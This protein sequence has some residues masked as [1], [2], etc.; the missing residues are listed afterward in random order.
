MNKIILLLFILF[1]SM[2][3]AQEVLIPHEKDGKWGYISF[4]TKKVVVP[5]QFDQADKYTNHGTASVKLGEKWGVL[6]A[7]GKELVPVKY[8]FIYVSERNKKGV[9]RFRLNEKWGLFDADYNIIVPAKYEMIIRFHGRYT[10]D[11]KNARPSYEKIDLLY[12]KAKKDG[13][14]GLIDQSD[15]VILSFK[16]DGIAYIQKTNSLYLNYNYPDKS[17]LY[18]PGPPPGRCGNYDI[19]PVTENFFFVQN[20]NQG[21]IIDTNEKV[22]YHLDDYENDSKRRRSSVILYTSR[23]ERLKD[24]LFIINNNKKQGGVSTKGKLVFP[25]EYEEITHQY[26]NIFHIKKQG[27]YGIANSAGDFLH[28]PKYDQIYGHQVILNEKHGILKPDYKLSLIH[29]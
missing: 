1:P 23:D 4:N 27:K 20:E 24:E 3:F 8:D 6:D 22:I 29:I 17:K 18:L 25:F 12:F 13:K 5:Y 9:T 7:D 10:I 26:E 14:W 16:Y 15:R 21:Q 11:S 28:P 19:T 2:V